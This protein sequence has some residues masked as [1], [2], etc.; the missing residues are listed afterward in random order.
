MTCVDVPCYRARVRVEGH[1]F[2]APGGDTRCDDVVDDATANAIA[3]AV[4]GP[5]I[6]SHVSRAF[7]GES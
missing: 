6:D 4:V 2:T 3:D 7:G 1:Y 5:Q